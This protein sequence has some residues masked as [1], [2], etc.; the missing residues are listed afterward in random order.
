MA[1]VFET[2]KTVLAGMLGVRRK[3]DHESASLNPVQVIV[4]GVVLAVLFVFTLI[5]IVRHVVG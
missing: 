1:G 5:A 4:A 2:L 3:S